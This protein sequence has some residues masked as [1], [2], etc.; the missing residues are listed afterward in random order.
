MEFTA[1]Y[2]RLCQQFPDAK[3]GD[4][5]LPNK[6][7]MKRRLVDFFQNSKVPESKRRN[8][9]VSTLS[10]QNNSTTTSTSYLWAMDKFRDCVPS[11]VIVVQKS[12]SGEGGESV[13]LEP[14][15]IGPL[16]MEHP[17]VRML[18]RAVDSKRMTAELMTVMRSHGVS[19]YDGGAIVGVVD[20]RKS[21]TPQVIKVW[22]RPTYTSLVLSSRLDEG[23][24]VEKEQKLLET[25]NPELYLDPEPP[26]FLGDVLAEY[27]AE[28]EVVPKAFAEALMSKGESG[29]NRESAQG[30]IPIGKLRRMAAV[31]EFRAKE[32]EVAASAEQVMRM[33]QSVATSVT[34][35]L[36]AP[37]FLWRT[38]QWEK[39]VEEKAPQF[40]GLNVYVQPLANNN[41]LMLMRMPQIEFL[42]VLWQGVGR[43]DAMQKVQRTHFRTVQMV[44]QFILQVKKM[45]HLEDCGRRLFNEAI[46]PAALRAN[47]YLP[48]TALMTSTT[49]SSTSAKI[50]SPAAGVNRGKQNMPKL[51]GSSS[52]TSSSSAASTP[53]KKRSISGKKS[54]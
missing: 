35:S 22:L 23:I 29:F 39:R 33:P 5:I 37:C 19:L 49:T 8:S 4:Q 38:V 24:D 13:M 20:Y 26:M 47:L 41:A 2:E 11:L 42:A 7:S 3:N 30:A 32:P 34:N 12:I 46:N 45:M 51:D 14:G 36:P 1:F 54:K 28:K 31:E 18:I 10:T 16:P 43:P 25:L 53:T 50:S 15:K 27:P 48:N 21:K 44:E 17:T 9:V 52:G 40:W 6:I